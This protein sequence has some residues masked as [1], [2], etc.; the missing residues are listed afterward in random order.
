MIHWALNGKNMFLA[1]KQHQA[2]YTDLWHW[3][4]L[5]DSI[6]KNRGLKEPYIL[7]SR[8][9]CTS[10]QVELE[11]EYMG[12]YKHRQLIN[13]PIYGQISYNCCISNTFKLKLGHN[14]KIFLVEVMRA[15]GKEIAE[16]VIRPRKVIALAVS[17]L[18]V[19][20]CISL[21]IDFGRF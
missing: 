18:D 16:H 12:L 6:D 9:K 17:T 8:F 14:V 2:S 7:T 10:Q 21:Y 15:T 11:E 3:E 5:V 13:D 20:N 19:T 1:P 4:E